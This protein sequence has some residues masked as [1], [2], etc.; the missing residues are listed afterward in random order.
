MKIWTSIA[1]DATAAAAAAS[2][3]AC[4]SCESEVRIGDVEVAT[5][6]GE[7]VYT[8]PG[9]VLTAVPVLVLHDDDCPHFAMMQAARDQKDAARATWPDR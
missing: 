7:P 8:A 3:A 2:I 1:S 9:R 5:V 4:P 6:S